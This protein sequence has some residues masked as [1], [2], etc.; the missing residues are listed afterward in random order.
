MYNYFGYGANVN[1]NYLRHM[2]KLKISNN[3]I[4]IGLLVG[5]SFYLTY[6]N[7]IDSVVASIKKDDNG[8]VF[9]ILYNFNNSIMNKINKQEF[10]HK[11]LY[12]LAKVNVLDLLSNKII[13]TQAY[14]LNDKNQ[15]FYDAPNRNIYKNIIISGLIENNI[16]SWYIRHIYNLFVI[17]E[18]KMLIIN[19]G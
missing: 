12:S 1:T 13:S 10:V 4:S 11:N 17:Y 2:H 14:I 16:P 7:I 18:K 6:S 8:I 19:N 5:Y 15:Y 9:G 3:S